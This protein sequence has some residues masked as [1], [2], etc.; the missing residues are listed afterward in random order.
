MLQKE[1]RTKDL[2]VLALGC[3]LVVLASPLRLLWMRD[4]S[5]WLLPFLVWGALIALG[6]FALRLPRP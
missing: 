4:D 3:A 6:A 2:A 1:Q 5:P